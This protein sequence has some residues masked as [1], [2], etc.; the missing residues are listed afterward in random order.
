MIYLLLLTAITV[1]ID[2]FICG[3]SLSLKGGKKLP[4]IFGIAFTVYAMCLATNYFA[5]I[6]ANKLNEKTACFSGLILIGIGLY[7]LLKKDDNGKTI[8][9][10][11]CALVE[12]LISGFA[13]GIDGAL[14]N[15]SLSLMGI[16][17]FY[18]PIIIA[19]MHGIMIALGVLLARIPFVKNFAKIGVL[20]PFILIFLGGYKLLGFFI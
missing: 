20:P 7:N 5:L 9:S 4:I 3:F 6:F 15:L 19:L 18:V 14:A 11:H 2:S 10:N 8:N 17:A 13:V 12:S 16:N 1:S